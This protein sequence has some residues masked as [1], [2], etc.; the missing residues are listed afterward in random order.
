MEEITLALLAYE[1]IS[2]EEVQAIVAGKRHAELR[3]APQGGPIEP[4]P[5]DPRTWQ[6]SREGEEPLSGHEFGG[7]AP[8]PA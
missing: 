4:S 5:G 1:T 8:S 2:G 7:A 6:K 3:P